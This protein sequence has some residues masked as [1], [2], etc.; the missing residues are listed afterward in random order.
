MAQFFMPSHSFTHSLTFSFISLLLRPTMRSCAGLLRY[1]ILSSPNL[2][3]NRAAE[4]RGTPVKWG[5][6]PDAQHL[7]L[8]VISISPNTGSSLKRWPSPFQPRLMPPPPGRLL[9]DPLNL[10]QNSLF[11]VPIA[12]GSLLRGLPNFTLECSL[13]QDVT[14]DKKQSMITSK[15]DNQQVL[16]TQLSNDNLSPDHRRKT[17]FTGTRSRIC[18]QRRRPRLDSWAGKIPWRKER[19]PTPVFWPGEFSLDWILDYTVH[20]FT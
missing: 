19:L 8:G 14:E 11:S 17:L 7:C 20:G 12:Q 16:S 13:L 18:L 9:W 4:G 2:T 1:T 6:P 15:L 5:F 10:K 3:P